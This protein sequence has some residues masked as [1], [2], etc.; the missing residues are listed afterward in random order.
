[1][2]LLEET[3]K[4][5]YAALGTA[6]NSMVKLYCFWLSQDHCGATAEFSQLAILKFIFSP[7][8]WQNGS[9]DCQREVSHYRERIQ[10]ALQGI[11]PWH[12]LQWVQRAIYAFMEDFLLL[13]FLEIMTGWALFDLVKGRH[14]GVQHLFQASVEGL[15]LPQAGHVGTECVGGVLK[16]L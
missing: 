2:P 7:A 11:G 3:Q 1:M 10:M 12:F 5:H 4:W 15:D 9:R 6:G 14:C 8:S 16:W 13:L